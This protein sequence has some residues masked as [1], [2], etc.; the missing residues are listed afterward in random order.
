MR[1]VRHWNRLSRGAVDAHPQDR[2]DEALS[3][4]VQQEVSLPVESGWDQMGFKLISNPNHPMILSL[5][6]KIAPYQQISGNGNIFINKLLRIRHFRP[7]L[8]RKNK[9]KIILN[10]SKSAQLKMNIQSSLAGFC[11]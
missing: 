9:N 10:T 6:N 1:A 11:T 4:L 7:Y 2:L 5:L 3:N 8:Q